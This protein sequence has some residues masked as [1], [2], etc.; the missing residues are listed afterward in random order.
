MGQGQLAAA[1]QGLGPGQAALGDPAVYR[2]AHGDP[3]HAGE[4]ELGQM[5]QRGQPAQAQFGFVEMGLDMLG[6][7]APRQAG[8]AA[9]GLAFGRLARPRP[10]ARPVAAFPARR[11]AA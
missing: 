6:D 8:E 10:S 2:A 7:A 11:G 5:G 1:Q 3:E 4:M 9:A